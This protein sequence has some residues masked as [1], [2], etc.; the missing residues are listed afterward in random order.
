MGEGGRE[1]EMKR[2]WECWMYSAARGPTVLY[3]CRSGHMT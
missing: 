1:S 2:E 3:Y